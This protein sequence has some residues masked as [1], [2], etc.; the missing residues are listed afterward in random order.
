[1]RA[2]P[3]GRHWRLQTSP[4]SP[5]DHPLFSRRGKRFPLF[6]RLMN[7][8]KKGRLAIICLLY[9]LWF[10]FWRWYGIRAKTSETTRSFFGG[11]RQKNR[12]KKGRLAVVRLL[13]ALGLCFGGDR[14]YQ[15]MT[16]ESTRFFFR[17][18]SQNSRADVSQS[19]Q[20]LQSI[21]AA[22]SISYKAS[23]AQ[24]RQSEQSKNDQMFCWSS[25]AGHANQVYL[26]KHSAK[27]SNISDVWRISA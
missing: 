21:L 17:G 18:P 26:K 5:V 20:C 23:T 15:S 4:W 11:Q 10:V 13:H 7:R 16:S 3:V 2:R 6:L 27:V 24:W 25:R 12:S 22:K 14:N 9:D 8:S 19:I 1:M